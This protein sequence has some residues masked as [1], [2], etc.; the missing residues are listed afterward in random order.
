MAYI[1][2]TDAPNVEARYGVENGQVK[3]AYA[4]QTEPTKANQGDRHVWVATKVRGERVKLWPREFEWV[5][6]S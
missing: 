5:P 4:F 1:R 3:I 2:I 6:S